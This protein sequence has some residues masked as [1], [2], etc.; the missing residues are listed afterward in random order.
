MRPK[1]FLAAVLAP[2]LAAAPSCAS[3]ARGPWPRAACSCSRV[4]CVADCALLSACVSACFSVPLPVYRSLCLPACLPV[5]VCACFS[6][7][8][9]L[10][11]FLSVSLYL[12]VCRSDMSVYLSV[13]LFVLS[14]SPARPAVHCLV[15]P[16][17]FIALHSPLRVV[18]IFARADLARCLCGVSALLFRCVDAIWTMLVPRR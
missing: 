17:R 1:L 10:S 16:L 8:H 12:S 5:C 14:Y 9:F 3:R 2:A 11:L 7:C 6:A 13:G 15:L 4:A 18:T